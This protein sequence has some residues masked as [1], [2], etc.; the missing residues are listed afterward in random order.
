MAKRNLTG[1]PGT[2]EVAKQ[3]ARWTGTIILNAMWG[4]FFITSAQCIICVLMTCVSANQSWAGQLETNRSNHV[5]IDLSKLS[6]FSNCWKNLDL[7]YGGEFDVS[8]K[9]ICLTGFIWATNAYFVETL[10]F[11][12]LDENGIVQCR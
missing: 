5:M 1:A 4:A 10:H 2:K 7:E 8:G 11:A 3:L 12:I 9:F 6:G